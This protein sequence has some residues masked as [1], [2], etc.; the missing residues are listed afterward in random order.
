MHGM[1]IKKIIYLRIADK[2]QIWT[3]E[4]ASRHRTLQPHSAQSR[5]TS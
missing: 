2:S 5:F 1:N 4:R 3:S